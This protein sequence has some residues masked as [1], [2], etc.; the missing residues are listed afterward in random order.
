[1]SARGRDR[2]A[3]VLLAVAPLLA[4]AVL[5]GLAAV[6]VG[7]GLGEIDPAFLVESPRD[8]GRA[9]GIGPFLVATGLVVGVALAA[10]APVGLAAAVYLAEFAP[11]ADGRWIGGALDALAAVPSVLFGLFGLAFFC[12]ALG[13]G[14]SVLSGGLTVAL[15]ILPLFVRL[16]EE[17]LRAVPD[18][19]RVAGAALGLPRVTVVGRILLPEAAPS[20]GAGLLLA[21]GRVLAESAALLFTAGA[22]VRAPDG[23][24]DPGRVLAVHVYL[25]AT[26]VPGGDA[27]AS[28]SALVLLG[29]VVLSG[30]LARAAPA[31]VLR[32]A[33]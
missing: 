10:A 21:T 2:V 24:L 4:I 15:M 33:R 18:E 19:L 8:A 6:L 17:G 23:L 28:A 32:R 26:E 7:R 25:L 22:A 31:L 13:L 29:V 14:W 11:R 12:E 9:G 5:A 1:M 27:R 16:A 20:I 3:A 30:W